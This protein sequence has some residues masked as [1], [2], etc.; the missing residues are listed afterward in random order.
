ML[1][2][3]HLLVKTS[4]ANESLDRYTVAPS[5]WSSRMV[6][7]VPRTWSAKLGHLI[8]STELTSESMIRDVRELLS[9]ESAFALPLMRIVVFL[10]REMRM[11]WLISASI[12]II[13]PG[14]SKLSYHT[15]VTN[16]TTLLS[17]QKILTIIHLFPSNSFLGG[18]FVRM[19]S[20]FFAFGGAG[21]LLLP[22]LLVLS[23]RV[24]TGALAR[25]DGFLCVI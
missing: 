11:E 19:L 8:T 5:T 13:S 9:S 7:R 1:M 3:L 14:E 16:P 12:S 4:V 18:F 21:L 2:L 24:G 10:Q 6:G 22:K 17:A 15:L 20:G 25:N 23:L